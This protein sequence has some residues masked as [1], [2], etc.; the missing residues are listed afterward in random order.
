[1]SHVGALFVHPQ[2]STILGH[3]STR[4]SD[5]SLTS[6]SQ[7]RGANSSS[8]RHV[9]LTA[10]RPIRRMRPAQANPHP[11]R[12]NEWEKA[13]EVVP[14]WLLNDAM[15]HRAQEKS[16]VEPVAATRNGPSLVGQTH[17]RRWDLGIHP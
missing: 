10:A 11:S 16:I 15:I 12:I 3:T 7:A 1:M 17:F 14:A 2:N 5:R 8:L 13:D 6:V 4:N 9:A